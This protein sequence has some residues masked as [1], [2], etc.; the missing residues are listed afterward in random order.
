MLP[1]A[2]I[3]QPETISTIA[4]NIADNHHGV[5]APA[6]SRAASMLEQQQE[7]EAERE[8]RLVHPRC[9][10]AP[11]TYCSMCVVDY[12]TGALEPPEANTETRTP[13]AAKPERRAP[14]SRLRPKPAREPKK[15]EPLAAKPGKQGF[16]F[17][18]IPRRWPW[19]RGR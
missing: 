15:G 9:Q 1:P 18:L 11:G 10:H 3:S 17:W 14:P 2:S 12:A 7:T 16:L 8:S 19:R 13:P 4:D 5:V 6:E